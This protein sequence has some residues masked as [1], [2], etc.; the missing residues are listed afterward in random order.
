MHMTDPNTNPPQSH[1]NPHRQEGEGLAEQQRSNSGSSSSPPSSNMVEKPKPKGTLAA[2]PARL[3]PLS[4]SPPRIKRALT[5]EMMIHEEEEKQS[6][7]AVKEALRVLEYHDSTVRPRTRIAPRAGARC[8]GG[9]PLTATPSHTTPPHQTSSMTS[10][11][12]RASW[13][14]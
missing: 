8:N 2:P 10:S 12:R 6:K 11:R 9:H 4:E 5:T 13:S 7:K 1:P 14:S 3:P